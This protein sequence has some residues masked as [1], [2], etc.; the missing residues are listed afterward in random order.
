MKAGHHPALPC[1]FTRG[2]ASSTHHLQYKEGPPSSTLSLLEAGSSTC[3]KRQRWRGLTLPPPLTSF[4]V[5]SK[6]I[7]SPLAW[8]GLSEGC[9]VSRATVNPQQWP[10]LI[11][12]L[13]HVTHPCC[14]LPWP[15][16]YLHSKVMR[17]KSQG[18]LY[19]HLGFTLPPTRAGWPPPHP[20]MQGAWRGHEVT[21]TG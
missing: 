19:G 11:M 18:S 7:Q 6:R 12:T 14:P 3:A 9:M 8:Q 13:N 21:D 17:R 16:R 5:V 10:E 2:R 4:H 1:C 20:P 15:L